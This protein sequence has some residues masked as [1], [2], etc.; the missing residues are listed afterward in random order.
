MGIYL[1]FPLA[2]EANIPPRQ[3][4]VKMIK[5]TEMLFIS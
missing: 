1:S 5:A 4:R 3:N 2:M